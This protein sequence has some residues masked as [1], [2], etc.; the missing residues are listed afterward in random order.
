[1]RDDPLELCFVD[2]VGDENLDDE[3]VPLLARQNI[4]PEVAQ[5]HLGLNLVEYH[6]RWRLQHK[7]T[8]EMLNEQLR[9]Q[10]LGPARKALLGDSMKGRSA[11]PEH[12]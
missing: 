2:A 11:A 9:H 5:I 8:P 1:M 10:E 7:P 6:A 3:F 12:A 4:R